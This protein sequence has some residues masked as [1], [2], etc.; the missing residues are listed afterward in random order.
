MSSEAFED[1]E[2]REEEAVE[3]G[4]EGEEIVEAVV[5]AEE[6]PILYDVTKPELLETMLIA[7]DILVAASTGAISLE[8]AKKIYE[9]EI[10]GRVKKLVA[11]GV[12][13]KKAKRAKAKKT[14]K[15]AK[16]KKKVAESKSKKE[17][18]KRK[19]GSKKSKTA[20]SEGSS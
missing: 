5:E 17:K 10:V 2:I 18:G 3:G 12:V 20:T 13:V 1:S 6:T 11:A 15:K 9:R 19:A 14:E 7:S 16:A 4:V 8:E